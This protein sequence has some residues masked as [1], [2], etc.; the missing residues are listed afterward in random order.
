MA[1]PTEVRSV[2]RPRGT[3]VCDGR[4]GKYPVREKLSGGY[5]VDNNGKR[6]R[7]S[8]NGKVVGYII[9]M[10]YVERDLP[11]PNLIPI[12]EVDLKSW[13]DVELIDR[14]NRDLLGLLELH[15]KDDEPLT[16][17]VSAVLKAA[18]EGISYR[19]LQREYEESFLTE[20]L[21]RVNLRRTHM[22]DFLR[23]IG[24]RLNSVNGFMRMM[25][26][27][28]GSGE[29]V[30]IDGTLRQDHSRVNSLSEISR[31]T[32]KRGYR[33]VSIMYAYNLERMEP[34]CS[35]VY[36]GNMVDQRAVGD[37]L[38]EFGIV[39]G[40]VV[41]D[42][43]FPSESLKKQVEENPELHYILPL[44][45]NRTVIDELGLYVFDSRLGDESG[46]QCKKACHEVDGKRIWY[47]SFRDPVIA[48]DHE[49]LYMSRHRGKDFD[50]DDLNNKRKEFGTIVFESDM[51]LSLGT[52]YEIYNSR[53]VIEILFRRQESDL[54]QDTTRVQSDYNV[55]ADNFIN[56]L[57][58][59][60]VS[61]LIIYFDDR[62]LLDR[63]TLGDLMRVLRRMKMTRTPSGDGWRLNRVSKSDVE[64][65]EKIG[66]LS[67]PVVPVEVKK[68]GRPKGSKDK[69]PR[70]RRTKA[71]LEDSSS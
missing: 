12:G 43:G 7:P 70:K 37:F 29:H 69:V 20:V 56:Y 38:E 33:E 14:L 49:M 60:M 45:R 13:G 18:N 3:V 71:E 65:V 4:D 59:I 15:F 11:D 41:A 5:Y 27:R 50:A 21:P 26:G 22:S 57:V 16:L 35:K 31:K 39:C 32:S 58:S 1:V 8:R 36:P 52:V 23:K 64:L 25:A 6:H 40:T 19:L 54:D 62:K 30:I 42:K 48:A 53:W 67:R 61:R 2:L 34:I 66:I 46:I 47:Y 17:Y 63:N 55:I 68:K 28:V 9:N 10:K 44:K 24:N 51:D